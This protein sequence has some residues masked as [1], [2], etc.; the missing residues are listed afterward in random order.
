VRRARR[1]L[2]WCALAAFVAAARV[3]DAEPNGA[4]AAPAS[5]SV[6]VKLA[7]RSSP[8]KPQPPIAAAYRLSAVPA[9]GMPL[10]V[11]VT[12]RADASLGDLSIEVSTADGASVSSPPVAVAGTK[13]GEYVW[14]IDVAPLSSP[15]GRLNVLV[16]GNGPAGPQARSLSVLLRTGARAEA[17]E[18][19]VAPNGERLMALPA[20]ESVVER[21]APED[22]R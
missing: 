5:G 6:R 17:A 10:R 7:A 15:A 9:I 2:C 13:Q 3:G 16:T 1:T 19:R 22:A 4:P 14:E 11:S 12:A 18:L 20:K 8:G 21:S